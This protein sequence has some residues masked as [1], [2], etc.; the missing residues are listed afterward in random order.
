MPQLEIFPG[1]RPILAKISLQHALWLREGF[2]QVIPREEGQE[3]PDHGMVPIRPEQRECDPVDEDIADEGQEEEED[4]P[5][6]GG[7]S[8]PAHRCAFL[9][10]EPSDA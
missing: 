2:R 10:R 4:E 6:Y 7:F 5:K 3:E 9:G 1:G 8:Q